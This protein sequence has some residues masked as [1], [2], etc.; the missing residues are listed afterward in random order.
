MVRPKTDLPDRFR[1]PWQCIV[2]G[3]PLVKH[4]V[5]SKRS[6]TVEFS[7]TVSGVSSVRRMVACSNSPLALTTIILDAPCVPNPLDPLMCFVLYTLM[8]YQ[9]SKHY[10]A[11]HTGT[12]C[13]AS[14]VSV[15]VVSP[16]II[17]Q[18]K[19]HLVTNETYVLKTILCL[20]KNDTVSISIPTRPIILNYIFCMV[21]SHTK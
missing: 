11:L 5:S 4:R 16:H 12:R 8:L 9:P 10:I 18:V 15:S 14:A 7:F 17:M 3:I 6:L 21:L 20:A 13:I 19:Q 2:V 1:R